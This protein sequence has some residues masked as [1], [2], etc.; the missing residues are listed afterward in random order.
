MVDCA[1]EASLHENLATL[2]NSPFIP[3]DIPISGAIDAVRTGR[4]Q[5]VVRNTGERR[6]GAT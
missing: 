2:R 6:V 5:E 3:P 1:H 4:L